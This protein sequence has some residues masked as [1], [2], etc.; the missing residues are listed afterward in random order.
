M[1]NGLDAK[2][3]INEN[4]DFKIFGHPWTGQAGV[5]G[6]G[7]LTGPRAS[8]GFSIGE[9]RGSRDPAKAHR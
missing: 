9:A 2:K 1:H 7:G 6:T 4:A 3:P 5:R 8:M